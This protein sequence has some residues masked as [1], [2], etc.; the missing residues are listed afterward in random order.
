MD[1]NGQRFY[2][3]ADALDFKAFR[4]AAYDPVRRRLR[5]L[6]ARRG[7]APQSVVRAR[8]EA[9]VDLVPGA[10][11]AYGTWAMWDGDVAHR[12]MAAGAL[13]EPDARE[14]ARTRRRDPVPFF[15]SAEEPPLANAPTD[16]CLGDDGV[17]AIALDGVVQLVD[18]RDR[19]DPTAVPLDGA[20]IWRL[21]ATKG[22]GFV[23]VDRAGATVARLTGK[24]PLRRPQRAASDVVARPCDGDPQPLAWERLPS[25]GL[26]A[27]EA[28]A[29]IA[30]APGGDVVA[31]S[32]KAD[33]DTLLRALHPGATAWNSPLRLTAG[34]NAE[35]SATWPAPFAMSLAFLGRDRFAVL[36][37]GLVD[38]T[39]PSQRVAEALVFDWP[40]AP[41]DAG[42]G[43]PGELL[44]R[45]DFYP[46]T[47]PPRSPSAKPDEVTPSLAKPLLRGPS[48]Q[49]G[50]LASAGPRALAPLSKKTSAL[51]GTVT[52]RTVDS[53][54]RGHAW[55]RVYVEAIVPPGTGIRLL[56]AAHDE[57]REPEDRADLA[58]EDRPFFPHDIGFVPKPAE[59]THGE[60]PPRA[61]LVD[62]ASEIPFEKGFFGCA[63]S[64]PDA[65]L[66][67]VLAQRSGRVVRTLS[68]RRLS[69]RVE[70]YGTGT[71]APEVAAIRVYGP[72]LSYVDRYLPE[73]YAE[74]VFGPDGLAQGSATG[75]D[76][77]TRFLS[78]VEGALTPIEDR[79][80]SAHLLTDARKTPDDALPWLASW[81]G[82]ALDPVIP[83][84][85]QR[86]ILMAAPDLARCHGT[87]RGLGLC[88]DALTGGDVA[89]GRVVIV[90]DYRM[91]RVFATIL[92]A[93]LE[94]ERDPLLPGGLIVSGNSYVGDTLFLGEG[95]AEELTELAA[96]Y[97]A[98][99]DD[100]AAEEALGEDRV[101]PLDG[102]YDRFAHRVT[103]LVHDAL[104]TQ[105]RALIDRAIAMEAPAHVEVRVVKARWPFLVGVASLV[106]V[107]SYLGPSRGLGTF[108]LDASAI[109]ETDVIR[110]PPSLDPRLEG[111][112]Q[113]ETP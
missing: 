48:G 78:I 34:F 38:V 4:D 1:A 90:E 51:T 30:M 91:R 2:L 85:C 41:R 72:R 104:T 59:N 107:D 21:A 25:L 84:A 54:T 5:V 17:V 42:P 95:N 56:L 112:P 92:G 77:L 80:A 27:G 58:P 55:H 66:Y 68:G 24:P 109:G 99:P 9:L 46:L 63:S 93:H 44:P 26:P 105:K 97:R 7:P 52:C 47:H 10:L 62:A 13:E 71:H 83:P 64:S 88:I 100:E 14:R 69:I 6:S 16:V 96:L 50:Y 103:V 75:S 74:T 31:L 73:L 102:F 113:E 57:D 111:T 94:D 11:D 22:S 32:W 67:T 60:P 65:G 28:L 12:V 108:R 19:F 18:A 15:P 79:V 20:R 3:L 29:A 43:R 49:A 39:D 36:V 37:P 110:R 53:H 40:L 86:A 23:A 82:L 33:G 101:D 106:G 89:A 87:L 76:F 45:G 35:G 98:D 81:V 61:A 70:L 8:A